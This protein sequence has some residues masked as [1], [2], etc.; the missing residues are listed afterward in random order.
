MFKIV[1]VAITAAYFVVPAH[2]N[3]L[4]PVNTN[5]VNANKAAFVGSMITA[6]TN[7]TATEVIRQAVTPVNREFKNCEA[8]NAWVANLDSSTPGLVAKFIGN[9]NGIGQNLETD[10]AKYGYIGYIGGC[11][12]ITTGLSCPVVPQ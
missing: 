12:D 1:L 9:G 6:Q 2:A 4:P 8:C 7:S 11:S 5:I 3:S 10:W